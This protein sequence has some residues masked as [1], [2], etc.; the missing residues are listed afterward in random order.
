MDGWKMSFLLGNPIFRCY[1][2]FPEGRSLEDEWTDV[3]KSK[4]HLNE[5]W[6]KDVSP[7]IFDVEL[8][9]YLYDAVKYRMDMLCVA[10]LLET[11]GSFEET[12]P[13]TKSES[14]VNEM[15]PLHQKKRSK[16]FWA[17]FYWAAFFEETNTAMEWKRIK[18]KVS[19]LS[20]N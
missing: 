17:K 14:S 12:F 15:L 9:L 2:S 19:E 4:F 7:W 11:S 8:T 10:K 18:D 13:S 3:W 16:R 1:V 20:G 6:R 5:I